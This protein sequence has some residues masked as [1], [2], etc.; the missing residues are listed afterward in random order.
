MHYFE[1]VYFRLPLFLCSPPQSP[2]GVFLRFFPSTGALRSAA[3]RSPLEYA[4]E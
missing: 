4:G 1:E 2:G 3:R